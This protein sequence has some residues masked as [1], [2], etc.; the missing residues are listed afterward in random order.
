MLYMNKKLRGL[1]YSELRKQRAAIPQSWHIVAKDLFRHSPKKGE[2]ETNISP[3][4]MPDASQPSTCRL[5]R[6]TAPGRTRRR[7]GVSPLQKIKLNTLP[8]GFKI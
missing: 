2:D 5:C 8:K 4:K 7:G 1:G 3:K 6:H